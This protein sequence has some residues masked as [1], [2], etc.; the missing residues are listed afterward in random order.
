M[1]LSC[2]VNASSFCTHRCIWPLFQWFAVSV[3]IIRRK[4]AVYMAIFRRSV[5]SS[6]VD[7]SGQTSYS[8]A[9]PPLDITPVA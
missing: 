1:A 6:Q 8:M 5:T 3:Q 9:I 7:N 2:Q 4:F